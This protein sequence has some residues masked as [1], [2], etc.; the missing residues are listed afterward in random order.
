MIDAEA[1]AILNEYEKWE[2]KTDR[3]LTLLTTI[4]HQQNEN[5]EI[6]LQHFSTFLHERG[7]S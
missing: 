2:R 1:D 6:F 3:I 7:K 4:N 5:S